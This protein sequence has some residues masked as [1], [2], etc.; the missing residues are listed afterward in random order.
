MCAALYLHITMPKPTDTEPTYLTT[1]Q[2]AAMLGVSV[3]TLKTWRLGKG[4]RIPP[5]LVEG[6]HWANPGGRQVLYHRE[7]MIDFIANSHRPEMHR[8]AVVAFLADLPSSRAVGG[9]RQNGG[10]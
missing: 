1:D 9:L 8:K 3:A 6:A 7:L 4:R 10:Q 5:R 2:C